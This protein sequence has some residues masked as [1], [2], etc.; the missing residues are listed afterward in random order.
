MM[1][2]FLRLGALGAAVLACVLVSAV[3]AAAQFDRGQI[4]GIVRDASG[5]VVPGVTITVLS[6]QTQVAQTTVTDSSGYYVFP[7]VR[8]GT[9]DVKVELQGFKTF[10]LTGQKVDA[11][12]TLSINAVLQPG[13]LSETITVTAESTPL[14]SDTQV[15][16]TID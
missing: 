8:P 13:D 7:N 1:R 5:G 15:R 10:A 2:G 12:A 3:P 14:Q 16:K 4:S 11:A 9:Y 6:Q